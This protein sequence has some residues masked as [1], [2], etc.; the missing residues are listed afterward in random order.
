MD[1]G[2]I[3]LLE[4]PAVQSRGGTEEK[5]RIPW[6]KRVE[7]VDFLENNARALLRNAQQPRIHDQ[8][9]QNQL[10]THLIEALLKPGSCWSS[11]PPGATSH[12]LFPTPIPR[13]TASIPIH[14]PA[15]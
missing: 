6:H 14:L 1:W 11:C 9:I 2:W 8:G 12:Q 7:Q 4:F 3:S 5:E 15:K 13:S 10:R